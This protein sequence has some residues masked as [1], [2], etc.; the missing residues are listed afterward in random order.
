MSIR[1]VRW[2]PQDRT[3]HPPVSVRTS[4]LASPAPG[5][6]HSC[7]SLY[8]ADSGRSRSGSKFT[9]AETHVWALDLEVGADIL[10]RLESLLTGEEQE[11]AWRFRIPQDRGRFVAARAMLR[12]ILAKYLDRDPRSIRF[13]HSSF[14]K[15]GLAA[16]PASG[17]LR[18]NATRSGPLGLVAVGREAELGIDVERLRPLPDADALLERLLTPDERSE[19]AGLAEDERQSRL[20]QAWV[21]KESVVKMIGLGLR[22]PLAGLSLHPWWNEGEKR[23]GLPPELGAKC[24]WVTPVAAPRPGFAAALAA[25]SPAGVLKYESWESSA[26]G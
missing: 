5:G 20:F 16:Q 15:P 19:L 18:F 17:T 2:A 8:A 3:E 7:A 26:V 12:Q 1:C 6:V 13:S 11:R 21:R 25:A 10:A 14:G 4:H 24:A 23:V 22:Q 9:S